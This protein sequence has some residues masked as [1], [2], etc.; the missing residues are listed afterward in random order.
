METTR[1]NLQLML[2]AQLDEVYCVSTY[3]DSKLR[4]FFRMNHSVFQHF[5]VQYVY[6]QVVCTL[7]EVSVHHSNQVIDTSFQ[8]YAK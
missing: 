2:A 1:D 3:T 8:I 5:T 4:I 6:V 7:H